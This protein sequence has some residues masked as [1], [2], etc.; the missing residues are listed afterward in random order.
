M[1][2]VYAC[3]MLPLILSSMMGCSSTT[4][5]ENENYLLD[6][7][8]DTEAYLPGYDMQPAF[9]SADG[10]FCSE[11]SVYY[12]VLNSWI[13]Y[14]D[15]ESDTSGILCGKPECAHK[16]ASCTA[17]AGNMMGC[18]QVYDG[19]LY[20]L[21]GSTPYCMDLD[22]TNREV[23]QKVEA[24]NGLSPQFYIHRGYLY[25]CLVGFQVTSAEAQGTM[26]IKRY[27]LGEEAEPVIVFHKEY[28]YN[29]IWYKCRFS[30]NSMYFMI[31]DAQD[32]DVES[33]M[34]HRELYEYHLQTG[35]LE[36]LW[37]LEENWTV[38]GMEVTE[39]GIYV[40]NLRT[41]YNVTDRSH[42]Y[43]SYF[44][45][46]QREMIR[47]EEIALDEGYMGANLVDGYILAFRYDE[48]KTEYQVYDLNYQ[49][50]AEGVVDGGANAIGIDE[51]GIYTQ[52]IHQ[53]FSIAEISRSDMHQS[54]NIMENEAM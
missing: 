8:F 38:Y 28:P 24:M 39:E 21:S 36:Q 35:E 48:D 47:Y 45:F 9:Q 54:R 52:N 13:F 37:S 29:N 17:Y 20:W 53:K 46:R 31:D 12:T 51:Y 16:D 25:T 4:N 14:Y 27:P 33:M 50:V 3:L 49:N 6:E 43:L 23:F 34:Q 41:D 26:E 44:D 22:G 42:I 1:K 11:G 18:I 30:G 15:R 5:P 2:R 10:Q 19:K 40:L 7:K 32:L